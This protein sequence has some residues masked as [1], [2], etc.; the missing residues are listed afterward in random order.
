MHRRAAAA[1]GIILAVAAAGPATASGLLDPGPSAP[2]APLVHRWAALNQVNTGGVTTAQATAAAKNFDL[3]VVK[4]TQA[5]L[6]KAMRAGNPNLTVLVYHNGAYAQKNQGTAF[7][8]SWYARDA[9]GNKIT[10]TVFGNYLMDVSNTGWVDNVVGQ[11]VSYKAKV[12]ADGC[13]TDMMTTAPLFS[14]YDTGLPINPATGVK[15][16]FPDYQAAVGKIAARVRAEVAGPSAANG[17]Q[18]GKRWFADKGASSKPIT[19]NTDAAHSEIW[20]RDRSLAADQWEPVSEWRQDVDMVV[21]A[22]A[23]GRTLMV[24]NKLWKAASTNLTNQWRSFTLATFLLATSGHSWYLF[25]PTKTWAGLTAADRWEN[26]AVGAPLDA[27]SAAGGGVFVRHFTSG[28][29]AVNPDSTAGSVTLPPGT[30]TDLYGN[31]AS[32][33]VPMPAHTGMVWR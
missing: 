2:P 29:V 13:Y 26:V 33:T 5:P 22:E 12:A 1:L 17:V 30:W 10:Q 31:S 6:V 21:E 28:F 8:E 19:D 27:Y 23:Q 14:G 20:L 7:P 25:T 3:V 18:S 15:W 32:G 11:C 9:N 24:E 4:N 16:T